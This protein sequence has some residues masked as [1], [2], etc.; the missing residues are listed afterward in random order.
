M[1]EVTGD[2]SAT[3]CTDCPEGT[4]SPY[5][6]SSQ[7]LPCPA[8]T[9]S[10]TTGAIASL[11]SSP[12]QSIK[13]NPRLGIYLSSHWLV[14]LTTTLLQNVLRVITCLSILLVIA[15]AI[16][17][18]IML[19][20]HQLYPIFISVQYVIII[21]LI[22]Q[23]CNTDNFILPASQTG[24]P[25]GNCTYGS[26][27]NNV[28]HACEYCPTGHYHVDGQSC[29]VCRGGT[30][31]EKSISVI[32]VCALRKED[33]FKDDCANGCS[34]WRMGGG[35]LTGCSGDCYSQGWALRSS[36]MDSGIHGNNAISWFQFGVTF[37]PLD[38]LLS[39]TELIA[40]LANAHFPFL[41]V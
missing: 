19:I 23:I 9:F 15:R 26:A 41:L 3:G 18:F 7:C 37:P 12:T 4:Y 39:L 38:M 11:T 28:T 8:N 1:I 34:V 14:G 2:Y 24:L 20:S 13:C 6:N 33:E 10:N 30:Y 16:V 5:S 31:A 21:C 35:F 29:Q 25:C 40:P 36:Y 32:H 27:R 17:R 22:S